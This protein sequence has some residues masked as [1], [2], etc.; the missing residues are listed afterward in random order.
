MNCIECQENLS[1]YL[2]GELGEADAAKVQEHLGDCEPCDQL[3]RDFSLLLSSCSFDETLALENSDPP[4]ADALWCRI[5]NMIESEMRP[6]KQPEQPRGWFS[7]IWQL[8]FAQAASAVAAVAVVSSLL[9]FVAISNYSQPS[10]GEASESYFSLA[11]AKIGLAETA[12]EKREHRIE[13]QKRAIAYWNKRVQARRA[14][15]DEQI[16]EAFDRNLKVIDESVNEY[17][18]ILQQD[19]DDELSSEMLDSVLN[20]KMNLLREFSEL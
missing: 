1:L 2:D 16:R 3:C 15:W 17:T 12:A 18:V 13:E 19:P 20:D 10:D 11:L 5:N 4:N 8:S 6:D 14:V 9:T 7:R